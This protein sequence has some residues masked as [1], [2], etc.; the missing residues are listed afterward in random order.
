MDRA[1]SFGANIFAAALDSSR[2]LTIVSILTIAA[3][4]AAAAIFRRLRR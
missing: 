2:V 4:F 1:L 3:L